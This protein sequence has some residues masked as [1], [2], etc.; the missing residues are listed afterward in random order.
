MLRLSNATQPVDNFLC[1][2]AGLSIPEKYEKCGGGECARW[3]I[4]EW[5]SC[6][7]ARCFA[8]NRARQ[9]RNVSCEYLNGTYSNTCDENDKPDTSQKC[10]NQL[11]RPLWKAGKWSEVSFIH[12][13]FTKS[14]I[15]KSFIIR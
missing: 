11:C 10:Y 2:D 9:H 3:I 4:G 6:L 1:E 14:K 7:E 8:P 12:I 15:L 5:E 13:F